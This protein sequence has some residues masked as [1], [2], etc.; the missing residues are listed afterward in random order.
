MET[1]P[2]SCGTGHCRA[3]IRFEPPSGSKPGRWRTYTEKDGLAGDVVYAIHQSPDGSLWFGTGSVFVAGW[4]G[5]SRLRI[6]SGAQPGQS[7]AV[8]GLKT[9]P[10][11]TE[12]LALAPRSLIQTRAAGLVLA[13]PSNATS[14]AVA[15]TEPIRCLAAGPAGA[16]WT[17]ERLGG[18]HLCRADGAD[19]RLTEAQGLP[20]MD[21]RV[22]APVEPDGGTVW[23]GTGGGAARVALVNDELKLER[24]ATYLDGLPTGPVAAMATRT[25]GAVFLAYNALDT[26][27]FSTPEYAQRRATSRV[28]FLPAHG[29]PGNPMELRR[30]STPMPQVEVRALAL[31]GDA[32]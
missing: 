31:A 3:P 8:Q 6:E 1:L 25:D 4:G 16:A 5:V 28:Y 20:A 15:S 11:H 27:W 10:D 29:H 14:A 26:K 7:G 21:V 9:Q 23:A 30:G 12:A 17:G 22:L 18:L 32:L 19:L 2:T 24:T 13:S